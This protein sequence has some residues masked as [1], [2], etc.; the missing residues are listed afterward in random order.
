MANSI[1]PFN[2]FLVLTIFILGILSIQACKKKTAKEDNELAGEYVVALTDPPMVPA[3]GSWDK[4]EKVIVNME[5]LEREGELIDGTR[6]KYWTFGGTVPGKFIRCYENDYIEFHLHNNENNKLPHSIDLH[7]VNGPGGGAEASTVAP[8]QTKV[9]GFRA[10]N[11]GLYIYHCATAPVGMHIG[12]GMYGLILV[13]DRKNPL[14]K[15][16]KEYYIVQGEFYTQGDYGAKGLQEFSMQK[17][18]AEN[19][20]YVVFNGRVGAHTGDRALDA[21]VGDRV[22]I[23]IGNGGP[24]LI[25]SFHVIGEILDKVY[26]EGGTEAIN[27][28]VQTTLIPAGGAAIVEFKINA[29]GVYN[30]VDHS[31]FRAFNK[32][33][34]AQIRAKGDAQPEIFNPNPKKQNVYL[35]EG[36]NIEQPVGE[37]DTSAAPVVR[38]FAENLEFGKSVFLQN[39]ASCH[40]PTGEGIV[41]VFPPLAKS[42]FLMARP[43][44][45]VGIV[46]NGLTG[47]IAVKG[48]VYNSVMPVLNLKPEEISAVLTYV[49][50]SW[51]NNGGEVT[52]ADVNKY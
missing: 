51:S 13:E 28:N 35:F 3:Q 14:P 29:P 4:P 42:D 34:L 46:K 48:K 2:R 7:A 15:V 32:G 44:K 10:L 17:A 21:K 20:D 1:F 39:C 45:G 47:A 8:G 27:K 5:V 24:N 22:R 31:I 37:K 43:D 30:L 9:F 16:D 41:N 26:I 40:Q 33:A 50:N 11:P 18:I 12:N 52:L 23:F 6:Y 36:S 38:S 25:S 19:P 49:R